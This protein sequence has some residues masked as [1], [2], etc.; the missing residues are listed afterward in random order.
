MLEIRTFSLLRLI[1]ATVVFATTLSLVLRLG[2]METVSGIVV[3]SA[4]ALMVLTA[5]Q[6]QFVGSLLVVALSVT[7]LFCLM[8]VINR[9][10]QRPFDRV[11]VAM[12]IGLAFFAAFIA[13]IHV[14]LVQRRAKPI[15]TN[16]LESE[17]LPPSEGG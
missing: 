14:T 6:R 3:C 9:Y 1:L 4:F 8:V 16:S 15:E 2:R 7:W 17:S 11:T 13:W 5:T 10:M 12:A